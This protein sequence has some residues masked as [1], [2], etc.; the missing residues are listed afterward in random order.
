[1]CLAIPGRVLTVN[2]DDTA[3]VDFSGARKEISLALVDGVAPDD[4]V[5]VHVGFALQ[6]IDPDEAERTLALFAEMQGEESGEAEQR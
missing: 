6:R 4:Y 2:E 5:L 3:L 1:M